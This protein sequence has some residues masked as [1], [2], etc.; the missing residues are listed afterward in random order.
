M[1]NEIRPTKNDVRVDAWMGKYRVESGDQK[2]VNKE[3]GKNKLAETSLLVALSV[4][5]MVLSLGIIFWPFFA[6]SKKPR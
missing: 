3:Q 6:A 4:G 2:R 5:V 1:K